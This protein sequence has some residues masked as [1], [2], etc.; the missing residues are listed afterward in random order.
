M[1]EY[2]IGVIAAALVNDA[3]LSRASGA[4][5]PDTLDRLK[6]AASLGGV[7]VAVTLAASLLSYLLYYGVLTPAGLRAAWIPLFTLTA[8]LCAAFTGRVARNGAGYFA[9]FMETR[10]PL[11]A[12]NAVILGAALDGVRT[13][14]RFAGVMCAAFWAS[15]AFALSLVLLTAIQAR[16]D[17][18]ALPESVRGMPALLLA[19]ALISMALTAFAGL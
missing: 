4:E 2:L 1:T 5:D 12:L 16:M 3:A 6:R 10:W 18:D 7:T 17:P 11:L 13:G 14:G 15:A 8:A 9:A 19:A